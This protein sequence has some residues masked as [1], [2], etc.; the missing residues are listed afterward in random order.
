MVNRLGVLLGAV[1]CSV[2]ICGCSQQPEHEKVLSQEQNVQETRL[3]HL[4]ELEEAS[5]VSE[6][7][8]YKETTGYYYSLLNRAEQI[9]YRDIEDALPKFEGKRELSSEGL[10]YGL[11]QE[12]IDRIFQCVLNDHPEFFYVEGYT[13]TTHLRENEIEKIEFTGTY[14]VEQEEAE[15]RQIQIESEAAR[16]L[17][18]LPAQTGEYEIIKWIYEYLIRSTEYDLTAQD[19]QNIYSVLIGKRSVCQ[20]YARAVQYMLQQ[21]GIE[22][23]LVTGTVESG[24]GHAWNLVNCDGRYYYVDATW[25]DVCYEASTVGSDFP[26][27]SYDYLCIT[28]QQLLRTHTISEAFPVPYCDS[29]EANYYVREGAYFTTVD[30]EQIQAVFAAAEAAGYEAVTL[31][32]AGEAV[33]RELVELLVGQ[34]EIFDYMECDTG[35]I[36]YAENEEQLSVTFWVTNK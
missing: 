14:S 1:L 5:E 20:G 10:K 7:S 15:L 33:Y 13:Y 11:T 22:C 8:L 2:M 18:Q 36:A 21:A 28:T 19:N 17:E 27:V 23:I 35:E 3:L 30:K 34:Q 29:M 32:C 24:E 31:K 16:I 12:D 25:G 26:A 6:R 4:D 9:W